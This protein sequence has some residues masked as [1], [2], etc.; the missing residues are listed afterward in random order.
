MSHL[1]QLFLSK[2]CGKTRSFLIDVVVPRKVHEVYDLLVIA[3]DTSKAAISNLNCWGVG[4]FLVIAKKNGH[5]I[6]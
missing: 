1:P 2:N 5:S 6:A 4:Y 3:N